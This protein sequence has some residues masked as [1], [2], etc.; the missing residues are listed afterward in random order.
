MR[1]VGKGKGWR[2][3]LLACRPFGPPPKTYPNNSARRR[4]VKNPSRP[5]ELFG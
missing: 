5:V 3:R 1:D 2:P 4:W